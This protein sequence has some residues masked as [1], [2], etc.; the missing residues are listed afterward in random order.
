MRR[1]VQ[2][3]ARRL[4]IGLALALVMFAAAL[5]S[6][7][8]AVSADNPPKTFG[9]VFVNGLGSDAM[10]NDDQGPVSTTMDG[11]ALRWYCNDLWQINYKTFVIKCAKG[12]TGSADIDSA[13]D[14]VRNGKALAEY[15]AQIKT[16]YGITD[17]VLVAHSMGGIIS[18]EFIE[19]LYSKTDA[20]YPHV[21]MLITLDTPHSGFHPGTNAQSLTLI[22]QLQHMPWPLPN[23]VPDG[24]AA[25][26][27]TANYLATFNEGSGKNPEVPYTLIAGSAAIEPKPL[28]PSTP[29]T[30]TFRNMYN[31]V[32]KGL[33]HRH[34]GLLPQLAR[35]Q[36]QPE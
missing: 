29:E 14:V 33:R 21:A 26:Q 35:L 5:V 13:G 25:E 11:N 2:G 22:G 7:P 1:Y 4:I 34:G 18:R 31:L 23:V 30:D 24:P 28:L 17:V 20:R 27:M 19:H 32:W 15:L 6:R 8:P 36:H 16:K 12:A 3:P 9:V 10:R